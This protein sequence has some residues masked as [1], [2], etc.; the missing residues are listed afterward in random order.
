MPTPHHIQTL[1]RTGFEM[2]LFRLT[3]GS[4]AIVWSGTI[5]SITQTYFLNAKNVNERV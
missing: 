1:A 5:G 4:Y 3:I 2:L